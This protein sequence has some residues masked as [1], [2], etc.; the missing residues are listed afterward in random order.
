MKTLVEAVIL[1]F[2]IAVFAAI[3]LGA[4]ETLTHFL[5]DAFISGFMAY[6]LVYGL[7]GEKEAEHG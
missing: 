5:G 2:G 7:I 6:G 3:V 1:L 4:D